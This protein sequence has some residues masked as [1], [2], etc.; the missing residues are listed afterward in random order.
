MI[1]TASLPMRLRPSRWVIN[2]DCWAVPAGL[3]GSASNP[4]PVVGHMIGG[5]TSLGLFT[6]PSRGPLF[7]RSS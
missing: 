7:R 1:Q 5:S 2:R 4:E 6:C 3:N